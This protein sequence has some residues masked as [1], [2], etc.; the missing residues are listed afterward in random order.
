[1]AESGYD[2]RFRAAYLEPGT[3]YVAVEGIVN[4]CD[5]THGSFGITYLPR[6]MDPVQAKPLQAGPGKNVHADIQVLKRNAHASENS[7]GTVGRPVA[8]PQRTR[9]RGLV[10]DA[11]THTPIVGAHLVDGQDTAETDSNGRFELS[12]S[13]S[14]RF[15]RNC[16][17]STE[18]VGN[19]D[20]YVGRQGYDGRFFHCADLSKQDLSDLRLQIP[21]QSA[22]VGKVETAEGFPAQGVRV[23]VLRYAVQDGQLTL[24]KVERGAP[25]Q[26]TNDLGEYSIGGLPP[27][28][29]FVRV[30]PLELNS[31]DHRYPPQYY[32]SAL[33]IREAHA[34]E[35]GPGE[36]R[37][38]DF[39]LKRHEGVT[40][41]GRIIMPASG[42]VKPPA[43]IYLET[44]DETFTTAPAM[45]RPSDG[46]FS[47]RHVP[48]GSFAL[49]AEPARDSSGTIPF[50]AQQR[51][52]I[53]GANVRDIV[54]TYRAVEPVDVTG[55]V[56][57]ENR[58]PCQ[59]NIGLQDRNSRTT[60][61]R[62]NDDGSFVVP[63]L[64]PGEY[65]V[66]LLPIEGG[67]GCNST[68]VSARLGEKEVLHEGFD[69]DGSP[70]G[71]LQIT[72]A[73]P[74][75]RL[76]GSVRYPG[77]GPVP[78]TL[79]FVGIS[80]TDRFL[81][82]ADLCCGDGYFSLVVPI[83]NYRAYAIAAADPI[84]LLLDPE[85]LNAHEQDFPPVRVAAGANP[86]L[87]LTLPAR[88]PSSHPDTGLA[89]RPSSCCR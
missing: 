57:F 43:R 15:V 20:I 3:Y 23:D 24:Q 11:V 76:E 42:G 86:T 74:T 30:S 53:G 35:V 77:S 21:P 1:V 46:S 28:R 27:G 64:P 44:S 78:A 68:L 32:P 16:L 36:Q 41:S 88:S 60:P 4:C 70:V 89:S 2:G 9:V 71:P 79:M 66:V 72:F 12:L 84:E 18:S 54:L 8:S 59:T 31:W 5:F 26:A 17:N 80:G 37:Q 7:A 50:L 73:S 22:I 83:G 19:S 45:S 14:Q 56:V 48:P 34:V 39:R 47:I 10:V 6:T 58:A 33:T 82:S 38:I 51:V 25:F 13:C 49:R 52:E 29:Y 81:T 67:R 55:Q 62:M 63:G 61:A 40:V 87:T 75:G 69:I 85:Y 65:R